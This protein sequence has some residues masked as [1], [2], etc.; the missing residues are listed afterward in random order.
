M[1]KADSKFYLA[2]GA[3]TISFMVA[4]MLEATAGFALFGLFGIACFTYVIFISKSDG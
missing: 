3:G 2:L 4:P 1:S